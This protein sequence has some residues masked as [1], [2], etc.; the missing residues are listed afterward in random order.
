MTNRHERRYWIICQSHH[1]I[2][3]KEV[4]E[5][6]ATYFQKMGLKAMDN[7]D[8]GIAEL[9]SHAGKGL[10]KDGER[11]TLE[12]LLGQVD[13]IREASHGERRETE[14]RRSGGEQRER[15]RRKRG[16]K[17]ERGKLEEES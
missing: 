16:E 9:G 3:F 12:G 1:L 13:K 2:P 15:W 14:H 4:K 8:P 7:A 11:P 10:P 5:V 6:G 17:N